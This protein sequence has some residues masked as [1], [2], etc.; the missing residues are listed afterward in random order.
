MMS[1]VGGR[2]MRSYLIIICL[3]LLLTPAVAGAEVPA[4]TAITPAYGANSSTIAI[5][6]LA[7][8]NFTT[9]ATVILTPVTVNPAHKGSI[10]NGAGGALL[11]SPQ[12]VFVS[13][14]YAYVASSGSNALEIVDVTNPSAPIHKG[15][16][17]NGAGG[18][19]LSSPQSVF[20]SGNY[21]YVA[22]YISSA[23]EIVDISNPAAPVHKGSLSNA[24]LSNAQSVFVAGNYAYVASPG[25]NALEIV[26]VTNPAV[27]VH[28]GSITNPSLLNPKSVF[29]AGNYAYVASSGSNVLEIVDVTNPAVPVH[30]GSSTTIFSPSSV[31]VSGNYAYVT[32]YGSNALVIVDVTNPA[33]PQNIGTI[34]NAY[35]NNPQ[36][37]FVAGNYAYVSSAGTS[38]ALEIVNVTNPANPVHLGSISNGA[39]GALLSN[40]KSVFVS[41]NYAHVASYGSN[42]LEIVDIGT[43]TATGVNVVSANKITCSVNLSNKVTGTYNVVVINPDGKFGT[44]LGGFTINNAPVASFYGTPL[45][46]AAPLTVTFTDTSAN[47]PTSWNWS[48]G[49]GTFSTTQNPAHTYSQGGVYTVSLSATSDKGTNTLARTDYIAVTSTENDGIAI[50]RPSSGYWYFDNYLDGVVDTSFRYGKSGDQPV[51]GNWQ[52]TGRDGIAI[53]RPSSGYW[54]FDYNL[55]GVVD[56]S[57]RFGKSGDQPIVGN[58]S[59]TGRDGIAIF[60][61][62]SGYWYFDYN[63]DGVVD[64]SFRFGKSGDQPV[65]GNWQGTGRDS[66]AIFRPSS[67]YWYFDYNLDGVVDNSFRFGKSGDQPVKGNWQGT[68]RDSIAIFRPASGYWYFDYNLSGVVDKSFRYGKL[69]DQPI[70]GDWQGTGRDGIAI[71]RPSSGYWYFDTFLD[72][73]VDTSFRYGKLGD[74]IIA[75]KWISLAPT[76][77]FT[78]ES[79]AGTVPLTV[80]FTSQST[81]TALLTYAWDFGDGNT[82][83]SQNPSHVYASVGTYSV[84]LTVTNAAGNSSLLRTDYITVSPAPE[85]PVA[86]FTAD[87]LSG[88]APLT[89]DFTSQSTGTLPRT[90]AWDFTNNGDNESSL[91]NPS[92]VYSTPGTYSVKLSVTNAA[93]S[94]STIRSNYITVTAPGI[95]LS[96]SSLSAVYLGVP[97]T[98]AITASGGTAPYTYINT[99]GALPGGLSLSSGGSLSGTP[100][101]AGTFVFTV[102]ATDANNFNGTRTYSLTVNS[103]P[104][105]TLSPSSLSAIYLGMPYTQAITASG[106]TAPYTYINTTGALPGGLSLS[107]GGSLSGTPIS[108]GTFVFTV[109]ATDANNFNG[110]R[111]YSLTVNSQPTITLSP[112]SLSAIYLGMP[113]TQAITASGGT[114]PYTYINTTG[115]LPGGLS[116][117]SGGSLSGTPTSAGTFVFTVNATDANNFNGTRTYSLT[118]NSQPTITL[119]PESLSAIPVDSP[120]TQAI[121]ASGGTAPYTYINTTGALPDG[122]SLST[123]GLISGTPT[124]TGT[125]GFRVNATDANNFNGTRLYSL[126]V[127]T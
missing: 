26:D 74:Q 88:T 55:S 14:N 40:P 125:F 59:G 122:L 38:N 48:F 127:T 77:A 47:N 19:L 78:A 111:T 108:A 28:K 117:S 107:S 52:G 87:P 116:L 23:L 20:V 69:D 99:T 21:A 10:S 11:S 110:T 65:K 25:S 41:G 43:V 54:Y 5:T 66:I 50:F 95:T 112:S 6:N 45:T 16:I 84:N 3:V 63:L 98:Q 39:G 53:F 1:A 104:T 124:V 76:A 71:F 118:V 18:A 67:G 126:E 121:T 15:N 64:N 86:A 9:G 22:S 92:H 24:N 75:A 85:A 94:N 82:S 60:R 123:E 29:L 106:G 97:Y 4:V 27:P 102:N 68:G 42:A 34:S 62:S 51:K 91:Q 105:I 32:S 81:G 115:A 37:V 30:K 79:S 83:A 90:Y 119:S 93:G 80:Q 61:P 36:S 49:D 46:G 13:G 100:T 57:F 33:I 103:Q 17:S 120:Y 89:V 8:A 12:G 44:L 113:Y 56:N 114:A 7:G 70:T 2:K 58:W 101:S 109:N 31:Y 35:L 72:G 73:V 96:P